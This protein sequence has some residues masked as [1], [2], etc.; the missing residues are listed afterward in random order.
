MN[1]LGH[2]SEKFN[3]YKINLLEAGNSCVYI[4]SF[5]YINAFLCCRDTVKIRV[6]RVLGPDGFPRAG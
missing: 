1:S 6:S 2:A 3:L 4:M 5:S